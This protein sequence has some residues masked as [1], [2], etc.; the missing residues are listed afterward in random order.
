[1]ELQSFLA[2]WEE[3]DH[4]PVQTNDQARQLYTAHIQAIQRLATLKSKGL[5]FVVPG[6]DSRGRWIPVYD[7]SK[8]DEVVSLGSEIEQ[9]GKKIK[10]IA[11]D[12]ET[13]L[14]LSGGR[15]SVGEIA[16]ERNALLN[17]I[18]HTE[19]HA[20]ATLK[21]YIDK[22]PHESPAILMGKPDVSEAYSAV[23]R[24]KSETEKPL[25]TLDD[26][27]GKIHAIL[28]RYQATV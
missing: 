1:M 3:A 22:N 19:R 18:R 17:R 23:Q 28:D 15:P 14:K 7:D 21:K 27:L 9:T 10:S 26:K 4:R 16:A 2:H 25:A 6:K 24:A 5:S 20:A 8:I 13:F 11:N 12:I